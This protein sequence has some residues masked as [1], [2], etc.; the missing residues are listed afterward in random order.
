M[1]PYRRDTDPHMSLLEGTV[2]LHSFP[3]GPTGSIDRPTRRLRLLAQTVPFIRIPSD[4]H[5]HSCGKLCT[6]IRFNSLRKEWSYSL[7]I[8][9]HNGG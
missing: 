6:F 5:R 4:H 9:L 3:C 8:S 7:P 2:A 1:K